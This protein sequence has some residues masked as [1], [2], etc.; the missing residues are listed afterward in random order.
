MDSDEEEDALDKQLTGFLFGNIDE[1]GRIES[2][3]LNDEEKKY[4]GGL[5]K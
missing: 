4:V 3:I 2:D 1:H 5:S